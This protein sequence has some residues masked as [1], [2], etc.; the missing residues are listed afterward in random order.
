M[1]ARGRYNIR[2]ENS[3]MVDILLFPLKVAFFGIKLAFFLF[4]MILLLLSLPFVI[5]GGALL[6]LK[7][8]F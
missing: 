5:L 6:M 2:R 3:E 4:L 1:G 8:L 7:I